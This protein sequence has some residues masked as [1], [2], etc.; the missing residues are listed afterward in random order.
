[1]IPLCWLTFGYKKNPSANICFAIYTAY[2][3]PPVRHTNRYASRPPPPFT[4][5]KIMHSGDSFSHSTR[6]TESHCY[7]NYVST[8]ARIMFFLL[9]R[10]LGWA[11][12]ANASFFSLR[13]ER[14]QRQARKRLILS[15]D[16]RTKVTPPP[17]PPRGPSSFLPYWSVLTASLGVAAPSPRRDLAAIQM[18]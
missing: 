9:T 11:N 5:I 18:W 8:T 12:C 2:T 6:P 4:A 17:H 14:T 13:R 7:W 1:M 3:P 16:S 15:S 10:M